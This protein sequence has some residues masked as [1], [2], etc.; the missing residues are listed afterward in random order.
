MI[1]SSPGLKYS[2]VVP[3]YNSAASLNELC[4]RIEKSLAEINYEIILVD[5]SS[6][7]NGWNIIEE[8]KKKNAGKI[9]GI[10]LSRNFGQHR[11]I[12]CGF[13]FCKG[14]FV[15]TIDDDLQHPPEEIIKLINK[16]KQ[17]Q[18]DLVYG[19]YKSKQHSFL[20]NS[21]SFF[22]KK[23]SNLVSGNSGKGSSFRLIKKNIIDKIITGNT[24]SSFYLDEVFYWHTAA[25]SYVDVEHH[26]RKQGKSGYNIFKLIGLYFKIVVNYSASP[27]KLMT[28][29]G[30]SFSVA[31]FLLGLRFIYKKLVHHVPLGYT[32]I[33]VTILFSAS[34]IMFCL[35]IIGQYLYKIYQ[36]QQNKPPYSIRKILR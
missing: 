5:D 11:A 19:I 36:A 29:F 14:D 34:I 28:W 21:G 23:S 27:L 16:Q 30:L 9:T 8:L 18:S 1:N 35:G 33:I 20:R 25:F 4:E 7:D 15:I 12:F 31:S 22:V 17:E 24:Q 2:I 13:T 10:R 3:V 32:S 26:P 6:S